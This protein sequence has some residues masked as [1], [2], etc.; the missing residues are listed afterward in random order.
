MR[1]TR[2]STI[3]SLRRTTQSKE[4]LSSNAERVRR[5][6]QFQLISNKNKRILTKL[7]NSMMLHQQYITK[8][9]ELEEHAGT[10]IFQLQKRPRSQ[11]AYMIETTSI[12]SH[13]F[14]TELQEGMYHRKHNIGFAS[15]LYSTPCFVLD[16]PLLIKI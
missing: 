8:K 9:T 2:D 12:V 11:R 6:K 13:Q 16:M 1:N 10:L 14:N 5:T 4:E 7:E 3:N 15:I